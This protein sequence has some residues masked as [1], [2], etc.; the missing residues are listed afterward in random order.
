MICESLVVRRARRPLK[1]SLSQG[2]GHLIPHARTN[3]ER[4]ERIKK[5]LKA[6]GSSITD[7]AAELSVAPS[8]V[9]IVCQGHR[10]SDRIQQEV[11][12]RLSTTARE[13]FPE[14]YVNQQEELSMR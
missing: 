2:R 1:C 8:T 10:T 14:R 12:K 13:L 11:A 5:A 3:A 4:H 6:V 9:T 7:I